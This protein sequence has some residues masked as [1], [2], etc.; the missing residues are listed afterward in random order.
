MYKVDSISTE[1]KKVNVNMSEYECT[2]IWRLEVDELKYT[3]Q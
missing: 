1:M 2:M 3:S